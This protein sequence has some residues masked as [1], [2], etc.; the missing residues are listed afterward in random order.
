MSWET[1]KFRVEEIIPESAIALIQSAKK[2]LKIKFGADPSAS[3]LHLG[4]AVVLNTLRLFQE[5]GHEVIFV[6]GDFTAMIGDPTGK[7]KTRQPLTK[8]QVATHAAS[9]QDQVFKILNPDQTTVVFNSSWLE[10]LSAQSMIEL[11]AHYTVARMLERDDFHQRYTSNQSIGIHEFLYPLL[12]GYD[13]VHLENDIEIGGTDQKFNLLVGRHLQR[14]YGKKEQSIITVPILEG[15]DGVQKMS[16]SLN[17][18]I[19]IMDAPQD[20]FGKIMSIPDDLIVRYFTLATR[21]SSKEIETIDARIQSGE[22]PRDLKALLGETIVTQFYSIEAAN[23]AKESFKQV[24]AQ[25]EV[26]DE[27]PEI[28]VT[29]LQLLSDAIVSAGGVSSKK[30][31]R[32][33]IDQGAVS[34]DGIRVTDPFEK[35][36]IEMGSVVKIGKRRFFRLV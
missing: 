35:V 22:N 30:E 24:F 20:M 7:S 29:E 16:K 27:M 33:M 15:L 18:H 8:A 6:I 2:P 17:N 10:S 4:H 14:E 23:K 9:Y 28:Q 5:M 34:I 26:P 31:F 36:T 25:K 32:R 13:S 1:V 3:D 21:C 11:S 19:G 12:Q